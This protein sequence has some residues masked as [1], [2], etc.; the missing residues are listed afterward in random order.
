MKEKYSHEDLNNFFERRDSLINSFIEKAQKTEKNE[1]AKY[2]LLTAKK[3]T[4][5]EQN[6]VNQ[7][8][9]NYVNK[10]ILP[11]DLYKKIMDLLEQ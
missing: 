8:G 11:N 7:L 4:D 6:K 9:I 3:I 5:D 10:P 2:I 1:K